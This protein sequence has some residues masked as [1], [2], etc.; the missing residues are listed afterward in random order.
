MPYERRTSVVLLYYRRTI[1]IPQVRIIARCDHHS[2]VLRAFARSH[3]DRSFREPIL[4]LPLARS[5]VLFHQGSF[6]TQ[7]ASDLTH[8]S[9]DAAR[10]PSAR[11]R[12]DLTH[13]E[14]ASV[15]RDNRWSHRRL[16]TTRETLEL[17]RRL[18]SGNA[19]R[20]RSSTNERIEPPDAL[21]KSVHHLA[22][23]G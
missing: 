20:I 2:R 7:R 22:I 18:L 17:A 13:D 16:V 11:R 14:H 5:H 6:V 19:A 21:D 1:I 4:C 3:D 10:R 12:G 9:R 15:M 23:N 8:L